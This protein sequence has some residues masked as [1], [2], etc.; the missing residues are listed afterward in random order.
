MLRVIKSSLTKKAY[1]VFFATMMISSTAMAK[2]PPTAFNHTTEYFKKGKS[3]YSPV[4]GE[5]GL[6]TG[7]IESIRFYGPFE[8]G[9]NGERDFGKDSSDDPL[10]N[11]VAL[12]FPSANGTFNTDSAGDSNFG[13]NVKDPKIVAKLLTFAHDVRTKWGKKTSKNT[14][15]R[16]NK[17]EIM[18]LMESKEKSLGKT[19]TKLLKS[20]ADSIEKEEK[21]LFPKYTTEQVIEGFFAYKFDKQSH[22]QTLIENL[23]EEIVNKNIKFPETE[24]LLSEKSALKSS[25]KTDLSLDDIYAASQLDSFGAVLPYRSG[26]NPISNGNAQKYDRKTNKLLNS[27]FADCVEV[28]IRHF[29]NLG[30]LEKKKENNQVKWGF[31]LDSIKKIQTK[32]ENQIGA[33]QYNKIGNLIDFVEVQTPD[34]INSGDEKIRSLSNRVFADLNDPEEINPQKMIDYEQGA[35]ELHPGFKNFVK[36]FQNLLGLDLKPEP[37]S[38]SPL[39]DQQQWVKSS[40]ETILKSLNPN[41]EYE[42]NLSQTKWEKSLSNKEFH[43]HDLHGNLHI[44]VYD[45][46]ENKKVN[47]FSYT[48]D[49]IPGHFKVTNIKYPTAKNFSMKGK[50]TDIEKNTSEETVA[51]LFKG[52]NEIK[53]SNPFLNVFKTAL[54]DNDRKLDFIQRAGEEWTNFTPEQKKSLSQ[55][56]DNIFPSFTW[57]DPYFIKAFSERFSKIRKPVNL[58]LWNTNPIQKG[59]LGFYAKD[60]KLYLK[61]M[62]KDEIEILKDD[63]KSGKGIDSK[64]Y[65]RLWKQITEEDLL[66]VLQF[67][68]S[69]GYA[70]TKKQAE[71]HEEF[72]SLIVPQV[73]SLSVSKLNEKDDLGKFTQLQNFTVEGNSEYLEKIGIP[74]SLKKLKFNLDADNINF[75]KNLTELKELTLKPGNKSSL[76]GLDALKNLEKLHI[77][78][79]N[80]ERIKELTFADDMKLSQLNIETYINSIIGLENLKHIKFLKMKGAYPTITLSANNEKLEEIDIS[81]HW[82]KDN[83]INVKGLGELPSLKKV[84]IWD[85]MSE[86]RKDLNNLKTIEELDF[87][88]KN[89]ALES[90]ILGGKTNSET[91]ITRIEKITGLENLPELMEFIAIGVKLKE[92]KINFSSTNSQLKKIACDWSDINFNGLEDLSA[93]ELFK[94][95]GAEQEKLTFGEN[96]KNLREIEISSGGRT[97]NDLQGV[98]DVSRLEKFT[99]KDTT[100][101]SP[102]KFG[103]ANSRLTEVDLSG[104]TIKEVDVSLLPALSKLDLSKKGE[105]GGRTEIEKITFSEKNKSI[106]ELEIFG[107]TKDLDLIHLTGLNSA[108]LDNLKVKN[109]DFAYQAALTNLSLKDLR[110]VES[111]DFSNNKKLEKLSIVSTVG[112]KK[113]KGLKDLSELKELTIS[114]G[115]QSYQY[116]TIY[117]EDLEDLGSLQK[118]E[119]LTLKNLGWN[120]KIQGL[121]KLPNLRHV[122]VEGFSDVLVKNRNVKVNPNSNMDL[123][124]ISYS[125]PVSVKYFEE[126]D[127]L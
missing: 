60:N 22:I 46:T 24:D 86:D 116:Q 106:K 115:G 6:Q 100:L 99:L 122:E 123:Y 87:S 113:I 14:E 33:P 39:E 69:S 97:I 73:R 29:L 118:L 78:S 112:L 124:A 107:P 121:E 37:N 44:N 43:T 26:E 82:Y 54:A 68:L 81:T 48:L 55:M 49:S 64:T 25:N 63:E 84:S 31:N 36:V 23:P 10:W 18:E 58:E 59:I 71:A 28:G 117:L 111:L 110:E 94:L 108:S 17:Q 30:T 72:L 4:L 50:N 80:G 45:N 102:L 52:Q 35:N 75:L 93:L 67:A 114:A 70:L 41:R 16:K 125:M 85:Q 20:I 57:D 90:I 38:N 53:I 8:P 19:V 1:P 91:N 11:V 32:F 77:E 126:E 9:G 79:G 21:S 15:F 101:I 76:E 47:L 65:E 7:L 119:K 105:W 56:M 62:G 109:L 51:L 13:K 74:T 83:F 66:T 27:T 120:A 2:F 104:A 5:I 40:L 98:G 89:K 61:V 34:L 88:S 96:N 12:L 103:E 92:K 95:T 127:N 42:I 3:A